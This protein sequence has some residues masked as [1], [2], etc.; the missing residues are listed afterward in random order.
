M[1]WGR[2]GS[3]SASQQQPIDTSQLQAQQAAMAQFMK[4]SQPR[5]L[6]IKR[7][8]SS[9]LLA[10]LL[11]PRRRSRT[12]RLNWQH[13]RLRRMPLTPA[14]I[15]LPLVKASSATACFRPSSHALRKSAKQRS[16]WRRTLLL[17][18]EAL[19]SISECSHG[20]DQSRRWYSGLERSCSS[21]PASIR[22]QAQAQACQEEIKQQ[23]STLP[24]TKEVTNPST[25]I[26]EVKTEYMDLPD[27]HCGRCNPSS[28]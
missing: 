7:R 16:R 12:S 11:T 22:E 17:P 10:S 18:P 27:C 21:S 3:S 2:R 23:W 24:V 13:S 20:L 6:L 9:R 4:Q 14:L 25:G 15:R 19:A 1:L 8:L 5:Q 26:K 28:G